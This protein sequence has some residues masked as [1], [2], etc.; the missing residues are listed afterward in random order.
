MAERRQAVIDLTERELAELGGL[1]ARRSTAQTTA[2]RARIVLA[3]VKRGGGRTFARS[4]SCETPNGPGVVQ[5]SG[6][7]GLRIAEVSPDILD[8]RPLGRTV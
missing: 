6:P 5:W 3:S 7:H 4:R 2:L 1:A 8:C